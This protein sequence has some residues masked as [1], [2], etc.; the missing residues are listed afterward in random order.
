MN[1]Q[2]RKGDE[3]FCIYFIYSGLGRVKKKKKTSMPER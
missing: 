2:E 3:E 1:R